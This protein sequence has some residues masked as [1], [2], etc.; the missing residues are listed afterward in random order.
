MVKTAYIKGISRAAV[1]Y[2]ILWCCPLPAE[3]GASVGTTSANFLKVPVAA[4]PTSLGEAYTAMV[5]PDSILYNPAG[6]GLLSYSSFSG[7]HNL[8]INGVTQEYVAAAYHATY[9]TIGFGFSSL[10][11]GK[12]DAYDENDMLIGKTSTSHQLWVLSYSQSWPHFNEDIGMLDPMLISPDWIR[13]EP[14]RKYRPKAYRLSLGASVRQISETL[15]RYNAKAYACDFGVLLVLPHH[16]HLG[17]SALNFGGKQKFV[18]ASSTLP[19]ELRAGLAKDFHSKNDTIV[20]TLASD[21]IKYSDSAGLSA[22]GL[23]VNILQ[24]FQMR[25]GYKTQK[26]SGSRLSAGMGMNFDR[27]SDKT[28]ILRGVRL[29]YSYMDYGGLGATSRIGVQF[30]W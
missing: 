7:S 4:I 10:S 17:A 30:I 11:S 19:S 27:L 26:D 23:E 12:I 3:A 25:L 29:D 28:S 14:V 16:F 18:Q 5:G 21:L 8:Y 13:V 1:L 2:G 24:M 22:T 9:G 15:D 6:L 20:F